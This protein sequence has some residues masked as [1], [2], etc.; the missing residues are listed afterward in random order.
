MSADKRVKVTPK[1]QLPSH[2]SIFVAGD[3]I[4]WPEQHQT[5][6]T[7]GH[8]DVVTANVLSYIADKPLTKEYK[9]SPEI[10][11]VTF[12]KVRFAFLSLLGL[13]RKLTPLDRV[14]APG[15]CHFC[16][17]LSSVTGLLAS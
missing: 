16:G 12:G 14:V 8:A 7:A 4:D 13:D 9:G 17:E 15:I 3:I 10:I 2:P 6:K 11:V 1:L 5:A